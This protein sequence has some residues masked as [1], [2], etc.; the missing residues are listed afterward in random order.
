MAIQKGNFVRIASDGWHFEE[1]AEGNA[2]VPIGCNY[3][4]QNIGWA[5]KVWT[6]FNQDDYKRDF[7]IIRDMGMNVVRIFLSLKPFM[8]EV[9]TVCEERLKDCERLLDIAADNDIRVIFSGPSAWEGT[10]E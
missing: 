6:Q 2:F 7:P 10:P 1:S 9:K 3:F 8:P 5:P 4:P